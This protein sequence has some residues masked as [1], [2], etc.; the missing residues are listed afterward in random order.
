MCDQKKY[1]EN[2]RKSKENGGR[3]EKLKHLS[4]RLSTEDDSFYAAADSITM[5]K[6]F[7]FFLAFFSSFSITHFSF[8]RVWTLKVNCNAVVDFDFHH[9]SPCDD[10]I[11]ANFLVCYFR[12]RKRNAQNEHLFLFFSFFG[13]RYC[14]SFYALLKQSIF[15]IKC[16]EFRI[17]LS[18]RK[19]RNVIDNFF[20]DFIVFVVVASTSFSRRSYFRLAF[21]LP[22]TPPWKC[23]FN[24]FRKCALFQIPEASKTDLRWK[25]EEK[26]SKANWN[27]RGE[28]CS[29]GCLS[30]QMPIMA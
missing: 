2:K 28:Q 29:N 5:A 23:V 20:I 22:L 24:C 30:C 25:R 21:L 19:N 12:E 18:Q 11:V 6:S 17:N 16:V 7:S 15:R 10:A 1:N 9:V 27:R 13:P 8:H 3:R 14:C 26:K 4:V